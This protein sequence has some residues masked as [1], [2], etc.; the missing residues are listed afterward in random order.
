MRGTGRRCLRARATRPSSVRP[1]T[2]PRCR[3][4]SLSPQRRSVRWRTSGCRWPLLAIVQGPSS[5]AKSAL[6]DQVK[7]AV[8]VQLVEENWRIPASARTA[9]GRFPAGSCRGLEE[10]PKALGQRDL[11]QRAT[12]TAPAGCCRPFLP[13]RG[14][15]SAWGWASAASAGG[16][17]SSPKAPSPRRTPASR[18][19]TSNR[20]PSCPTEL[21]GTRHPLGKIPNAF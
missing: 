18:T 7:D 8:L 5:P 19:V 16:R 17:K 12:S 21:I 2:S 11:R 4:A 1:P 13:L 20:F 3:E 10:L 15:R 6:A 14:R 9:C